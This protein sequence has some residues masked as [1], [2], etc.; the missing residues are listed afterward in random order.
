MLLEILAYSRHHNWWGHCWQ[1]QM[2]TLLIDNELI[3][4]GGA[5]QIN[6]INTTV[7]AAQV[8]AQPLYYGVTNKQAQDNLNEGGTLSVVEE[9][10]VTR[11]SPLQ[12]LEVV[13]QLAYN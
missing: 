12:P 11:R 4:V 8:G 6:R 7:L 9:Q 13:T 10:R 3:L 1:L 2:M 5:Y